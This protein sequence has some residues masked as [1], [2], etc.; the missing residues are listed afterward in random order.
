MRG[1]FVSLEPEKA[2]AVARAAADMGPVRPT[3][4][5]NVGRRSNLGRIMPIA[6]DVESE[7]FSTRVLDRSHEKP[8]IVDFWAEWCGPCKVLGPALEAAVQAT[9][10]EVELA[11]VDVDRNQQ[12]AGQFGIQGIPTVIAFKGGQPAAR[13]TGALPDTQVRQWVEELRP[14]DSDRQVAAAER[15][16]DAGDEDAALEILNTV[17]AAEPTHQEAGLAVAALRINQGDADAALEVLAHLSATEEVAHLQAAAR[18]TAA[19]SIDAEAACAALAK[20]P[21]DVQARLHV[22]QAAAAGGDLEDALE[23]LL[24]V[25]QAKADESEQARQAMIDIFDLRGPDDPLVKTYRTKLASAL[26]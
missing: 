10:G 13:F 5:G 8:I 15:L 19:E 6:Y 26:F 1:C 21:D 16:L 14:T 9:D 24:A 23:G 25:V 2:R 11:K 18:M 3:G 17:L 7:D 4:F 20:N 22:A 12:L